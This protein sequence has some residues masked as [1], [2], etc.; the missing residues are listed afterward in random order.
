MPEGEV[1][2]GLKGKLLDSLPTHDNAASNVLSQTLGPRS[3]TTA[4]MTVAS[5]FYEAKKA[6]SSVSTAREL[7]NASPG[8]GLCVKQVCCRAC[9]E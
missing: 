9:L 8:V 2:R 5:E 6:G 1:H 4:G 3:W 7:V